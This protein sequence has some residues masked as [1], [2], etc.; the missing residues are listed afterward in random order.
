VELTNTNEATW[1]EEYTIDANFKIKKPNTFEEV[2]DED[3]TN[4][5]MQNI[6]S[7]EHF[8]DNNEKSLAIVPREGYQPFGLFHDAHFEEYIFSTLFHGHLNP[9]FESY[10][11][12]I[13]QEKLININRKIAYHISNIYLKTI[14]VLIHFILSCAYIRIHKTKL[15]DHVLK[16]SNV[17]TNINLDKILK[18]N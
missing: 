10:Y 8:I 1:L 3:C 4:T 11:Q 5:L 13:V 7:H 9:S 2:V 6:L 16:A 17:S 12:K 14:K 18:S 15:L